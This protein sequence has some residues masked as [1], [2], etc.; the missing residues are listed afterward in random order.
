MDALS[1]TSARSK[2]VMGV[3]DTPETLQLLK[4]AIEAGGYTFIGVKGGAQCLAMLTRVVPKLILLDIEMPSMSGF[5]T[6]QRIRGMAGF[7]QVPIAFLTARKTAEDVK[8]GIAAGGN[9]FIIKPYVVAKLRE[10][11][12]YWTVRRAKP[13]P[14]MP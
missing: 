14:A 11:V 10:R 4:F 2:I 1:A 5:E 13:E 9:D 12:D 6:C 3:D 7:D 8:A